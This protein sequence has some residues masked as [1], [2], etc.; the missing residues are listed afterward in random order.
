MYIPTPKKNG[1]INIVFYFIF[2]NEHTKQAIRT[3]QN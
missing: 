3:V 1:N 2:I